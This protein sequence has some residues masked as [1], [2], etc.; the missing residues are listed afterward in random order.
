[1]GELGRSDIAGRLCELLEL[2]I[3]RRFPMTI[4]EII[5]ATGIERRTVYRYLASMESSG[6][7]ERVK[8]CRWACGERF[9]GF[10]G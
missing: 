6:F 1:M 3:D 5:E 8:P 9:R 7:V 2:F 4:H 10:K